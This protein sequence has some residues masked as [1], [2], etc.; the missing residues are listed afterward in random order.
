MFEKKKLIMNCDVC[1][2]RK[3]KEED[4]SHYESILLNTD[5]MIVS[6]ESKS[7]LSRLPI[8]NNTDTILELP[9]DEKINM[10][11]VNGSYEITGTTVV[12]ENTMLTVNGSLI[13]NP[14]TE[15][16]LK[17][18]ARIIVNGSVKY[19]ESL[20]SY[21][22][23]MMVNG[24][25]SSYP[26]DST[27]LK[28]TFDID[29]YFPIRAKEGAKYYVD[30]KVILTDKDVDVKKLAEKNVQF[31]TKKFIVRESKLEE[32]VPLFDEQVEFVVIPDD[33][34]FVNDD[35]ELDEAVVNKYGTRLYIYGDLDITDESVPVLEKIEKLVVK[36]G[37]SLLS[38]NLEAFKAVDAEYD[39]LN[40]RK[41]RSFMNCVNVTVDNSILE[42]SPEGIQI[43]NVAT[44]EIA[45]DIAV[46]SILDK[47]Q[48]ENC[49]N[50]RC[51]DEQ[52]SAVQAISK[53][54]AN[55]GS[56]DSEDNPMG[57]IFGMFKN[58][59]NTKVVNADEYVM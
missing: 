32:S 53:N 25:T 56:A 15:D 41:G 9:S 16:V 36:G 7:I 13:I 49:A 26:D 17:N 2:T 45:E 29:K 11:S 4:Y 19:P 28:S 38:R 48:I 5:I 6:A 44:V 55:V 33:M 3:I 24:A 31:I 1:D 50:V 37:V 59:M 20:E 46:E 23:N 22:N 35:V 27:V 14:G 43:K 30:S 10:K 57:D 51:T 12:S 47:L 34:A 54:V 40:V 42:H 39:E 58:A 18:Y 52:K 21:L 8:V